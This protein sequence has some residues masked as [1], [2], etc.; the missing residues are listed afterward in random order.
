M[1]FHRTVSQK[2]ENHYSDTAQNEID[3]RETFATVFENLGVDAVFSGHG[4]SYERSLKLQ[5]LNA[6]FSTVCTPRLTN[7]LPC[8]YWRS[9]DNAAQRLGGLL[10]RNRMASPRGVEPLL[11]G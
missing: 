5:S 4:H 11:P 2:G 6:F 8:E 7:L 9:C 10:R 1:I 3:M